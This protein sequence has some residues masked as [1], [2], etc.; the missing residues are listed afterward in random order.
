ML[1]VEKIGTFTLFCKKKIDSISEFLSI[2]SI[3]MGVS[4]ENDEKY[5]QESDFMYFQFCMEGY[6][7]FSRFSGRHDKSDVIKSYTKTFI[8]RER[9]NIFI[10]FF[11]FRL[12]F[13]RAFHPSNKNKGFLI[14]SVPL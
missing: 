13:I 2:F 14:M 3:S 11:C 9:V 7:K 6:G 10:A 4:I 1:G 12:V 5:H 8:F